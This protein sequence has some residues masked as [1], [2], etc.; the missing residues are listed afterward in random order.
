[1]MAD[2]LKRQELILAAAAAFVTVLFKYAAIST[3]LDLPERLTGFAQFLST[4]VMLIALLLLVFASSLLRS[5]PKTLSIAVITIMAGCAIFFS[6]QIVDNVDR[7]VETV[8]CRD[9]PS[10]RILTPSRPSDA[11]REEAFK[12]GGFIDGWC[13][14]PNRKAFRREI[15]REATT[16]ANELR[17]WI[18]I[19]EVLFGL[20]LAALLILIGGAVRGGSAT[21]A[22]DAAERK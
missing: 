14:H 2:F 7:Q 5:L 10:A 1:M 9:F 13:D 11:L 12:A 4:V 6:F 22:K 8:E 16:D 19:V 17:L 21:T 15:E 18:L 20:S 3:R